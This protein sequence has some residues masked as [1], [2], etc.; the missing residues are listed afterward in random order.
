MNQPRNDRFKL[1]RTPY[2]LPLPIATTLGCIGA[3]LFFA[4]LIK[5]PFELA[6]LKRYCLSHWVC[7]V[8]VYLFSIGIVGLTVKWYSASNQTR[9]VGRTVSALRRLIQQGQEVQTSQ[10]VDWMLESWRAEPEPV[11]NS[12]L[13]GRI[14]EALQVQQNRGRR[15][16]LEQDLKSLAE[17]TGDQQHE[18][19]SLLRIVHWAM[20][21]LGFLGTVLGISQTLGQLDTEALATQGQQAMNQ[22][23]AGLYVAFDTTA[24]A[25]VLT[26]VSMFIQFGVNRI[27]MR[28]M[29]RIDSEA[30]TSLISFIAVDP[31]E[32]QDSL[33]VPV[34]EMAGDLLNCVRELVVE[35]AAIWSRSVSESQRQWT[36]WT[37]KLA[38]EVDVNLVGALGEAMSKHLAGLEQVQEKSG[39]Q[40]ESRL[41][42]W[43]TTLS[44]QTRALHQQ[45]KEMVQQTGTLQQLIQSTV[46]LKKLEEAISTNIRTI[47]ESGSLNKS[48]TRIETATQCVAEAV[49]MLATSLERAGLIRAAPQR[50]RVARHT[51]DND[52]DSVQQPQA[53]DKSATSDQTA[54]SK[55][56]K[57]A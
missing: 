45:Q 29:S 52:S 54:P 8:T 48:T 35:Q 5:G 38:S 21:M 51:L 44:E 6:L 50:P 28:L 14:V 55:R 13:G 49:A 27:E 25:L 53:V 57:A 9:I 32:A 37:A 7:V 26:M 40:F 16:Y 36:D 41:Q 47:E 15:N 24:I 17:N 22:L 30:E 33:I 2:A 3:T 42:Q 18:S 19:Y 12:W 23:T 10:R 46:D 1:Q 56:G 31:F 11:R 39:R 34:R 4:L 43:Q 20:P